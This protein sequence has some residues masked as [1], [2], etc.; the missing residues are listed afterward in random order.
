MRDG[1]DGCGWGE[2]LAM[3]VLEGVAGG[4]GGEVDGSG[5]FAC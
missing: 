5:V 1:L 4:G 2:D 3:G